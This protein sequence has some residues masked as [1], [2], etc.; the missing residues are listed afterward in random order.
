MIAT[1]ILIIALSTFIGG[2]GPRQ[3]IKLIFRELAG[4][5]VMLLMLVGAIL[6]CCVGWELAELL[7]QIRR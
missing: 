3:L 1:K 7:P 5:Y 6:G 2:W 4:G